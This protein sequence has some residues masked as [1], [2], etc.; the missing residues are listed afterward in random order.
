[1]IDCSKKQNW[2][3]KKCKAQVGEALF[4]IVLPKADNSKN[5][6]RPSSYNK[7]VK[8]INRRFGGSTTKPITLGCEIRNNKIQCESGLAIETWLDFDSNPEL[9]KLNSQERKEKLKKDYKFLREL[10][11]QSAKDFGQDS[12]PVIFDNITDV[13][14]NKGIWKKRI[15]K[16]KLTGKK[17]DSNKLWENNI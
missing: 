14:L 11:K 7:Y 16:S 17:I 4:T 1:M 12:V 13:S 2:K 10:A 5:K 6:I 9:K 3:N 15:E 8:K